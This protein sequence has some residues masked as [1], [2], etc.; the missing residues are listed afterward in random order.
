MFSLSYLKS[1]LGWTFSSIG[2]IKVDAYEKHRNEKNR[3][4]GNQ[5]VLP[6]FMRRQILLRNNLSSPSEIAER[7][8]EVKV[9]QSQRDRTVKLL[10]FFKVE[11]A[12]ES[13]KRKAA[14]ATRVL[15]ITKKS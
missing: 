12:V 2:P 15:Y 7:T 10:P 13:A 1:L 11:E 8:R 9:V 6:A 5:L 14:R 4:Q 3:R